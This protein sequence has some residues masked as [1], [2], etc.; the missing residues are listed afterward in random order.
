MGSKTPNSVGCISLGPWIMKAGA[1]TQPP[2]SIRDEHV[3]CEREIREIRGV[4]YHS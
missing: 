2:K 1:E 4:S 3:E